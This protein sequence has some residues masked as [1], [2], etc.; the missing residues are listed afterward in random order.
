M[1]AINPCSLSVC[2]SASTANVGSI[3]PT[4]DLDVPKLDSKAQ[5]DLIEIILEVWKKQRWDRE[6]RRKNEM[7]ISRKSSYL[8]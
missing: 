2:L 4:A 5:A 7:S 1:I 3:R 8:V 6:K